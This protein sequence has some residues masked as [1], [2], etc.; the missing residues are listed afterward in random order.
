MKTKIEF[1]VDIDADAWVINFGMDKSEVRDDVKEHA[2]QTAQQPSA[3]G[4]SKRCRTCEMFIEY[5]VDQQLGG[6]AK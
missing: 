1:T 6:A 2:R 3:V 5:L 4:I